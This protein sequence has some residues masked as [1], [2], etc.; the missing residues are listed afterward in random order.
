MASLTQNQRSYRDSLTPA[1]QLYAELCNKAKTRPDANVSDGLASRG[2]TCR[3]DKWSAT[4]YSVVGQLSRR[5]KG[6]THID[7]SYTSDGATGSR[8]SDS[9]RSRR[10]VAA[11][12]TSRPDDDEIT[13]LCNAVSK[14]L[15]IC[16]KLVKIEMPGVKI[17]H[18]ALRQLGKGL[19]AT[20]SLKRLDLRNCCIGDDGLAVLSKALINCKHLNDLSLSGNRLKDAS[21]NL[22]S[23][24]I[25]RH[26]AR[27]D[28]GF[29]ASCLRDGAISAASVRNVKPTPA[30]MSVQ[31]KGLIAFDISN[32]F[33]TNVGVTEIARTL[34][35]DGWLVALN[36]RNNEVSK[37]GANAIKHSLQVNES[38]S[39]I[40][41]R[42]KE[43]PPKFDDMGNII[44]KS[45]RKNRTEMMGWVMKRKPRKGIG[46]DHPEV[47]PVLQRWGL[48]GPTMKDKN[49]APRHKK[50]TKSNRSMNQPTRMSSKS[51]KSSSTSNS[52]N[53]SS[54]RRILAVGSDVDTKRSSSPISSSSPSSNITA[55]L[56]KQKRKMKGFKGKSSISK[57]ATV[58][59]KNN[60]KNKLNRPQSAVGRRRDSRGTNSSN[61]NP[62][63]QQSKDERPKTATGGSR[64]RG[65]KKSAT[66][67]H[68][69]IIGLG[70]VEPSLSN[71]AIELISSVFN[72]VQQSTNNFSSSV[73][74]RNI[75]AA[76][77]DEPSASLLLQFRDSSGNPPVDLLEQGKMITEKSLINFFE[78]HVKRI[79]QLSP[80]NNDR[81]TFVEDSKAD[82][83]LLQ[84]LEGWVEKLHGYIDK[85]E[86]GVNLGSVNLPSPNTAILQTDNKKKKTKGI[87]AKKIVE[88]KN[89]EQSKLV[90]V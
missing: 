46:A 90:E 60:S 87:K 48:V 35:C 22:I 69:G 75:I 50:N 43:E 5:I 49:N 72:K 28:D 6:Y 39:V 53:S 81:N 80:R 16:P 44:N 70:Q 13:V 56:T 32:N 9:H 30:E 77:R 58:P 3:I 51:K 1:Q 19:V 20:T 29:W 27:R 85:L 78:L 61:N 11:V 76:L 79:R 40:D 71:D 83:D 82:P 31:L 64:R 88:K 4:E 89:E 68:P 63:F 41:F 10:S 42:P 24:I 15:S 21:S 47:Q 7:I 37:V 73:P 67:R 34:E 45:P 84:A 74:V 26:S 33:F 2:L 36:L 55:S 25:R 12:S 66:T 52:S 18:A 54:N 62:R 17:C 8:S 57:S 38:L 65:K 86:K 59:S 23:S 14:S